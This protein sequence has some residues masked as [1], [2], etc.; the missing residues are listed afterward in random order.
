MVGFATSTIRT[1]SVGRIW[2]G[3]QPAHRHSSHR[4]P[5][6]TATQK[7]WEHH[8]KRP[9][10]TTTGRPGYRP[11]VTRRT[12]AASDGGLPRP[13]NSTTPWDA[14]ITRRR[15]ATNTGRLKSGTSELRPS[16]GI[17]RRADLLPWWQRQPVWRAI[18]IRG[19]PPLDSTSDRRREARG[20]RRVSRPTSRLPPLKKG[21][22]AHYRSHNSHV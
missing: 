10:A 21:A 9:G 6:D 8:G 18:R 19:D 11:G 2:S 20:V 13:R 15:S 3:P 5:H 16:E 4:S 14:A 22:A 1:T 12:D 7:I 17:W